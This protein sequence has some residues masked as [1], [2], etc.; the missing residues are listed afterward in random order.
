MTSALEHY[1]A[2]LAETLLTERARAGAARRRA[3]SARCCCGTRSRSPSTRR[4]RSTSSARPAAPRRCASGRCAASRSFILGVTVHTIA[5]MLADRATYNRGSL[6]AQPAARC[7]TRRS[8]AREMRAPHRAY[9]KR[10][11]H[12]DDNDNTE[13]IANGG[14]PSCSASD[15]TLADHLQMSAETHDVVI[16]GAGFGGHGRGD[17]VPPARDRR[18]RDARGLSYFTSIEAQ[19]RHLTRLF[20]ELRRGGRA[21]SETRRSS[22]AT[23]RHVLTRWP[24]LRDRVLMIG[25]LALAVAATAQHDDT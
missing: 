2:T 1:T 21:A 22:R 17:R 13:L 5:S 7:G 24:D 18:H 25:R 12:P 4:S 8:S 6:A 9:N 14:A 3:R 20:R 19:M 16:V 10:G 11:F 15:G 23:R